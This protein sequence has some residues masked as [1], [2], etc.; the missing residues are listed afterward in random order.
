MGGS[1]KS[2]R[3]T[4]T[5]LLICGDDP[6]G[7]ARR[8]AGLAEIASYRLVRRPSIRLRD[9]YFDTPDGLLRKQHLAVRLRESDQD[10]LITLKGPP[11]PAAGGSRGRLE[12]EAPWSKGALRRI[13]REL[14][15][16]GI[17]VRSVRLDPEARPLTV[18][19]DLGLGVVQSRETRRTVRDVV[20][21]EQTGPQLAE[22]AVD[23]VVY[24]F[25]SERLKLHMIEVEAK[26]QGGLQ[27]LGA[28]TRDLNKMFKP[29]L[30]PWPYGKLATGLATEKL[31]RQGALKGLIGDDRH[32]SS[33]VF[34]K[35][36][37]YLKRTG[38][39]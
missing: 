26:S 20:P 5:A 35:L 34:G 7:I 12:I 8:V 13:T 19:K 31:L 22:L 14:V 6:A 23:S 16:R 37:R 9:L 3:E 4:E 32:L 39:A 29:D 36:A 38:A 28:I 25:G 1:Q 27:S 2:E 11:R 10:W 33:A 21:A 18:M 15:K 17:S 30:C 24:R